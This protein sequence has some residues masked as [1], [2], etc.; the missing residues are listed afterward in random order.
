MVVLWPPVI[1]PLTTKCVRCLS[2]IQSKS[3]DEKVFYLLTNR[4]VCQLS[5]SSSGVVSPTRLTVCG[6]S[7]VIGEN[8]G[9][10]LTSMLY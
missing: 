6:Y 8:Y 7:H 4:L 3:R 9:E 5:N 2:T 1:S 10:D